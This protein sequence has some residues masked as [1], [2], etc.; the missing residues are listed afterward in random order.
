MHRRVSS[1]PCIET[2]RIS[3]S[4]TVKHSLHQ[5]T[6][7]QAN[8]QKLRR[9]AETTTGGL[10]CMGQ[11]AHVTVYLSRV[12]KM[13]GSTVSVTAVDDRV[14]NGVHGRNQVPFLRI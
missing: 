3:V 10:P 12:P 9:T 1:S 4:T 6:Y 2:E 7:R 11:S 5:R 8:R 14:T 13:P